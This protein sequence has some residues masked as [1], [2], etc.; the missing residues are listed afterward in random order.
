[1]LP[2]SL[3][4]LL[5]VLLSSSSLTNGVKRK[6]K[7]DLPIVSAAEAPIND[8]IAQPSTNQQL[9]KADENN[10]PQQSTT[11]TDKPANSAAVSTV[12]NSQT[13]QS[14]A[15][16]SSSL[17]DNTANSEN[18]GIECDPDMIGFEIITG[19][20]KYIHILLL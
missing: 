11:A 2:K 18:D 9:T 10:A 14:P 15:A 5:I 8:N 16:V 19:S 7:I 17:A 6:S 12:T 20:V 4:L 13:N 3:N 1:M